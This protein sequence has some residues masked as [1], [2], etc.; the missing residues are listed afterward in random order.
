[1]LRKYV[2]VRITRAVDL[3]VKG[4][5]PPSDSH[6]H[7]TGYFAMTLGYGSAHHH[8]IKFE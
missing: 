4:S 2:S 3:R 8:E 6:A 1:M 7:Y 5:T